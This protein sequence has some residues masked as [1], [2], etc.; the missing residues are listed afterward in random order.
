MFFTKARS[1]AL[2]HIVTPCEGTKTAAQLGRGFWFQKL[3]SQT[4]RLRR[5]EGGNGLNFSKFSLSNYW[6]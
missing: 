1:V 3:S 2:R 5:R 4:T 6:V